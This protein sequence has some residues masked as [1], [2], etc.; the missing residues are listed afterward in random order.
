MKK[1]PLAIEKAI[2]TE[3]ARFR[4]LRCDRERSTRGYLGKQPIKCNEVL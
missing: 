4:E 3:R 1:K 2:Y